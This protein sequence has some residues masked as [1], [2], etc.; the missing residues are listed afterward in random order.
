MAIPV[1]MLWIK[2]MSKILG[3]YDVGTKDPILTASEC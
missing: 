1:S 3:F 2:A